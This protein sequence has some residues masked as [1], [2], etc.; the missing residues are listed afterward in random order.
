[1][2]RAARDEARM[3]L[4]SDILEFHFPKDEER[5]TYETQ[6]SLLDPAP[7]AFIVWGS[8]EVPPLPAGPNDTL[9]FVGGKKPLPDT[10]AK[11]TVVFPK[12]KTYDDNNE[13]L[14]WIL[15][16]GDHFNIDLS[17]IASAL[18]VN[19]GN[20][21]RKLASEIAKLAAVTPPGSVVTPEIAR[22]LICFSAELSPKEIIDSISDGN[23]A[24]AL[25][26]HDKLQERNEE[27]GWIL[28]YMQRHVLQQLKME[29]L[30]SRKESA[31]SAADRLGVHPYIYRKVLIPRLG[32]WT[33]ESLSESLGVLCDLDIAHKRGD[34]SSKFGLQL[35]IIRLS[36][37]AC[38]VIKRR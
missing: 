3:S 16:E 2:E 23:T 15:K 10:R 17:R 36:Q 5:Y 25:A 33:K 9:V 27:T 28:A 18:F 4:A 12:L 20:C 38:D 30:Q 31:D 35:E 22:G 14:R 7:R 32:L 29:S 11:R 6:T 24:K 37:E 8:K 19:S 1:M 13:V 21:L 26:Y 34:E